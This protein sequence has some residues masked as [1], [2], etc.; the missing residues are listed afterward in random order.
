MPLLVLVNP[1]HHASARC[2]LPGAPVGGRSGAPSRAGSVR[3]SCHS[4]TDQVLTM[5]FRTNGSPLAN[6][7]A[8]SRVVK[9]PMVER[10]FPGSEKGPDISSVR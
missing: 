4:R 1:L 3:T 5:P 7:S 2:G 6:A 8:A 9:R 10:T